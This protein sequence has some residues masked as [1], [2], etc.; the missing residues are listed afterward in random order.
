MG[1]PR[2]SAGRIVVLGAAVGALIISS[3][4]SSLTTDSQALAKVGLPLG[5]GKIES[6]RRVDG[7]HNR[8]RAGRRARRSDLAA[9][10]IPAGERVTIDVVVKRPGWIAWLA[11]STRAASADVVAPSAQAAP[12]LRDAGAGAP[13]R[14]HFRAPVAAVC[15]RTERRADLPPRG[16]ARQRRGDARAHRRGRVGLDRG[17]AP[18]LG[19]HEDRPSSAGSRR[20]PRPP[21]WPTRLPGADQAQHPDHADVLEDGVLGTEARCRR[22]RRS[23]A[24]P[25]TAQQPHDRVPPRGIRLRAWRERHDWPPGRRQAGR[26]S[27]D[28]SV[29]IRRLDRARRVDAAPPAAARQRSATC[30]FASTARRCRRRRRR[31]RTRRST[32]RRATSP[33]ATPTTPSALQLDVGSRARRA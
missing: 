21:R 14:L 10:K 7:P 4:S 16:R 19:D 22:C 25:G 12:D 2:C 3:A 1:A 33:G 27:G 8:Q 18:R 31:R 6:V 11:G 26:R 5:G 28:G 32:R 20:E 29:S 15:L 13:L 23:R 30:R 24:G 9:R 17:G